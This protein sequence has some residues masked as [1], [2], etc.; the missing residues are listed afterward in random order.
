[1]KEPCPLTQNGYVGLAPAHKKWWLSEVPFHL[2]SR[3][4]IST[5]IEWEFQKGPAWISPLL[6]PCLSRGQL[7]HSPGGGHGCWLTG[8]WSRSCWR[9]DGSPLLAQSK[10]ARSAQLLRIWNH[11][12]KKKEFIFRIIKCYQIPIYF[13][14]I[15]A[16]RPPWLF[17]SGC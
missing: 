8:S 10:W 5:H 1:M 11:L 3:T 2:F 16:R 12:K 17:G 14:S 13:P 15:L 6:L 9:S 4:L 7:S